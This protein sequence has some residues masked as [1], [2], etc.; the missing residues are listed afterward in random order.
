MTQTDFFFYK[1]P[2][3]PNTYLHMSVFNILPSG[4][5]TFFSNVLEAS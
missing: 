2:Q 5:N 1:K 3:L 4:V